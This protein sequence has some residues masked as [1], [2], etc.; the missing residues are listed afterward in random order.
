M[1]LLSPSIV[2]FNKS[3]IEC[4]NITNELGCKSVHLDVC[5]KNSFTNF[6]HLE[7]INELEL[8]GFKSSITMHLF[9]HPSKLPN[10]SSLLRNQDYAILHAYPI[11]NNKGIERF[12]NISDNSGYK[13]GLSV[14]IRSRITS[15]E[16]Y[17]RD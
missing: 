12:L 4:Q 10:L 7:E 5:P 11:P 9:Y 8:Q 17:L 16:K 13:Y 6:F 1:I 14:N 15:I 3:L 2:R